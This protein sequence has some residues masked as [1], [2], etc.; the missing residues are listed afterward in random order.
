MLD[1]SADVSIFVAARSAV[2]PS[3]QSIQYDVRRYIQR[4]GIMHRLQCL[5]QLVQRVVHVTHSC[6]DLLFCFHFFLGFPPIQ[7]TGYYDGQ[8]RSE[9]LQ[10]IVFTTKPHKAEMKMRTKHDAR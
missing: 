1:W 8:G 7:I 6:F 5:L 9:L 2:V 3:T 4:G 10:C